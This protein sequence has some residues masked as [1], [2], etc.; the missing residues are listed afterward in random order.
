MSEKARGGL[1]EMEIA[2][3]RTL[4]EPWRLLTSTHTACAAAKPTTPSV[5]S[6]AT[7]V[8][9]GIEFLLKE[10]DRDPDRELVQRV[11]RS[12]ASPRRPAAR[13][14][15]RPPRPTRLKHR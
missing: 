5:L 10:R 8:A 15:R 6:S 11:L 9:D 1:S 3:A 4:L 12:L 2:A 7:G 13:G 14:K